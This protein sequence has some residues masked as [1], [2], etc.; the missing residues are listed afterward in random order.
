MKSA[1]KRLIAMYQ[2][3]TCCFFKSRSFLIF[4]KTKRLKRS[5]FKR[6]SFHSCFFFAFP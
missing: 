3:S 2:E 6:H 4:H 1:S 5:W